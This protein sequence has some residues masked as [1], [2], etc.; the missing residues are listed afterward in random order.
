MEKIGPKFVSFPFKN[1]PSRLARWKLS[2][3]KKRRRKRMKDKEGYN[4]GKRAHGRIMRGKLAFIFQLFNQRV[5][6]LYKAT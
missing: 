4:G 1:T 6:K 3:T 5:G 2:K